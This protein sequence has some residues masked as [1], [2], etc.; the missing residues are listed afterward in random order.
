MDHNFLVI[1]LK[2]AE[3]GLKIKAT[4]TKGKMGLKG[5]QC[6]MGCMGCKGGRGSKGCKGCMASKGHHGCKDCLGCQGC[7]GCQGCEGCIFLT[8]WSLNAPSKTTRL[9]RIKV[10]EPEK[11]VFR[12]PVF[13]SRAELDR[14]RSAAAD[15]ESFS[16]PSMKINL[17]TL[18]L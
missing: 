15:F 13:R 3:L 17:I 1:L 11:S 16:E 2:F 6:C 14:D 5:W 4:T 9:E 18:K 8:K 12:F 7:Q 10:S